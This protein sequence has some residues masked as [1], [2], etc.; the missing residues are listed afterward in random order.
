M[1]DLRESLSLVR[2]EPLLNPV[3][4]SYVTDAEFVTQRYAPF[5]QVSTPVELGAPQSR[6]KAYRTLPNMDPYLDEFFG[7][8]LPQEFSHGEAE[9]T[10][11]D[12]V[13]VEPFETVEKTGFA[14]DLA[15]FFARRSPAFHDIAEC[16]VAAY[17]AMVEKEALGEYIPIDRDM[18][19]HG[20]VELSTHMMRPIIKQEALHLSFYEQ[21]FKPRYE[22]LSIEQKI[23]F[24]VFFNY[25]YRSVGAQ[26]T[27]A[28]RKIVLGHA[29]V[30]SSFNDDPAERVAHMADNMDRYKARLLLP[31]R[32]DGVAEPTNK[33]LVFKR[34]LLEVVA[35]LPTMEKLYS[36]S[37]NEYFESLDAAA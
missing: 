3:V 5:F 26:R 27:R 9:Q 15:G 6:L 13:Q 21:F 25:M 31:K 33:T 36:D 14:D 16:G 22:R 10:T 17:G 20:E 18:V 7:L 2:D 32:P 11:L 23:L 4:G 37:V 30:S 24:G 34:K 1:S 29:L 8:W 28:E 35:Q 19:E 12:T